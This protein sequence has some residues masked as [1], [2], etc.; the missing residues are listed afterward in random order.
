MKTLSILSIIPRDTKY[1]K[2]KI[3][4]IV[5]DQSNVVETYIDNITVSIDSTSLYNIRET[6]TINDLVIEPGYYKIDK[7]TDMLKN[8]FLITDNS[9]TA[10]QDVNLQYAP[11]LKKILF[12]TNSEDFQIVP[13]GYSINLE[14]DE[15]AGMSIIKIYCNI[16]KQTLVNTS[17]I[18]V[19]IYVNI[20]LDN[21]I[22]R[23]NV[24]IPIVLNSNQN[25][26]DFYMT[27]LYEEVIDLSQP[28]YVN[29]SI[30]FEDGSY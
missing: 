26:I 25:T 14:P 6:N 9:V 2:Q 11:C 12:H 16:V 15:L 29:M 24:R 23:N 22:M 5:I 20:G 8:Y 1:H 10:L 19:P 7:L 28:V 27:N 30:N 4:K 17:L 13:T 21:T 18:D 3:D